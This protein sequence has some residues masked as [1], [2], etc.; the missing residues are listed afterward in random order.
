VCSQVFMIAFSWWREHIL[1]VFFAFALIFILLSEHILV[2][3]LIPFSKTQR[4]PNQYSLPLND[5]CSLCYRSRFTSARC[6]MYFRSFFLALGRV[7]CQNQVWIP[8]C[9]VARYSPF[10]IYSDIKCRKWFL[11]WE[12]TSPSLWEQTKTPI[13]FATNLKVL[14]Q[15]FVYCILFTELVL[16]LVYFILYSLVSLSLFVIVTMLDHLEM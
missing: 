6:L 14:L 12:H 10:M 9:L 11:W 3:L 8:S 13:S 2:V 15:S 16:Q 1:G 5:K 4:C 7:Y